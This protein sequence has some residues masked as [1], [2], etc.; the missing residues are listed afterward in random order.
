MSDARNE[1]DDDNG[2]RNVCRGWL[3]GSKSSLTSVIVFTAVLARSPFRHLGASWRRLF[4]FLRRAGTI[5]SPDHD[6]R[7]L[8][9]AHDHVSTIFE[10]S[11]NIFYSLYI[12]AMRS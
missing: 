1:N 8:Y 3:E 9:H 6:P 12:E 2:R 11:E 10:P 4:E 7:F 5:A